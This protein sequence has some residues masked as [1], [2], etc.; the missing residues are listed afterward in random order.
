M[1]KNRGPILILGGT[2]FMGKALVEA[3]VDSCP[4]QPVFI[5]NRGSRYWGDELKRKNMPDLT[6]VRADRQNPEQYSQS[7]QEASLLAKVD[8]ENKWRLVIDFC[9]FEPDDLKPVLESIEGRTC[10]YIFIST[11]SLYDVCV[12]D[13]REGMVRETDSVRPADEDTRNKFSSMDEYGNLK[14]AC[15]E[16]LRDWTARPGISLPFVCLRLPDVLG[17]WDGENRFWKYVLWVQC[18]HSLPIHMQDRSKTH[19]LSF[20]Y[21]FDI[22]E[23]ILSFN[24]QLSADPTRESLISKVDK[25]SFHL[26]VEETPTLYELLECIASCLHIDA[27]L[28]TIDTDKLPDL[29]VFYL[30]TTFCG[31]LSLEKSKRL[32][33]WKPTSFRTVIEQTCKFFTSQAIHY[34][35]SQKVRGSF[36]A[37]LRKFESILEGISKQTQD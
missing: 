11:D 32:L 37:D 36:E 30:P 6:F 2:Q 29:G 21:S 18:M 4:G 10:L 14:L 24:A 33:D 31:P 25:Q 9:G 35:E 17:P 19:R 27:G 22:V 1:E 13:I 26:A 16:Y 15:E 7:I 12:P 28:Q 3:L 5:V 8:R 20:V 34:E 23:L